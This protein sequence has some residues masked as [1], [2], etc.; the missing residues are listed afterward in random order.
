MLL[1]PLPRQS[2]REELDWEAL[3]LSVTLL[4]KSP[5]SRSGGGGGVR[6]DH[7][8]NRANACCVSILEN[9]SRAILASGVFL[10]QDLAACLMILNAA[11]RQHGVPETLVSD[12]RP[13]YA[14]RKPRRELP[15]QVAP[16]L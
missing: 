12:R 10:T 8:A 1:A 9:Y 7:T 6:A 3:V 11:I 16:D 2:G 14:P 5:L 4:V 13:P 15:M